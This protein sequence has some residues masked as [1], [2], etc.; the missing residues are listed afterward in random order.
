MRREMPTRMVVW[1]VRDVL[2]TADSI[3]LYNYKAMES[4][5]ECQSMH[6]LCG[7]NLGIVVS[8]SVPGLAL[9]NLYRIQYLHEGGFVSYERCDAKFVDMLPATF[10]PRGPL[11]QETA[12]KV[13]RNAHNNLQSNFRQDQFQSQSFSL[14]LLLFAT[15]LS[16]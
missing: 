5:T 8:L 2:R 3:Q 13:A 7:F 4:R 11:A 12:P 16:H 9:T 14:K 1:M 6:V 15:M 10:G